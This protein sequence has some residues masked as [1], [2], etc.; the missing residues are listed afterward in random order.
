VERNE[1]MTA[2]L[3]CP[4]CGS[5]T[6]TTTWGSASFEYGVGEGKVALTAAI[7]ICGCR[8]CKASFQ[9]ALTQEKKNEAICK[10][11]GLMTPDEIRTMRQKLNLSQAG[12]AQLSGMGVASI[13]R[14]ESGQLVQSRSNDNLLRLLSYEENFER[15]KNILMPQPAQS[16]RTH[17]SFQGKALS[18]ERM[19]KFDESKKQ[20]SLRKVD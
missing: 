13:A 1:E 8:A 11:L 17:T 12:L 15:L 2:P 16:Q 4:G 10:H 7:P 5:T 6:V 14:W 18:P 9:S 19:K 3:V 20:F